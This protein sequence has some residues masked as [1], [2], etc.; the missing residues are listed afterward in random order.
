MLK[1]HQVLLED[2]QVE[3]LKVASEALDFSLSEVL[4]IMY[5]MGLLCV[6]SALNPEYKSALTSGEVQKMLRKIA[7][8]PLPQEETHKYISKIYFEAR[9]VA[10]YRIPRLKNRIK[11]GSAI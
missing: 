3:Y 10:E 11:G 9:K 6:A 4:R 7:R 5:S 1:R 8:S 2:W